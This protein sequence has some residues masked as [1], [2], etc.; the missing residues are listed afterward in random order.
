MGSW[1][2]I[3]I[4]LFIFAI[5]D[6]NTCQ[7]NLTTNRSMKRDRSILGFNLMRVRIQGVIRGEEIDQEETT[8]IS[9]LNLNK[10][11]KYVMILFRVHG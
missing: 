5:I 9:K 4:N 2:Y 11:K 8:T 7:P 10:N 6:F 1:A 3:L